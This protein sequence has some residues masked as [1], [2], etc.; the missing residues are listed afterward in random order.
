MNLSKSPT[1]FS[2]LSTN[3]KLTKRKYL[4]IG[5]L[6]LMTVAMQ[7]RAETS[8]ADAGDI[9]AYVK[10]VTKNAKSVNVGD[11]KTIIWKFSTR[12]RNSVVAIDITSDEGIRIEKGYSSF[13]LSLDDNR[14]YEVPV[15]ITATGEGEKNIYFKISDVSKDEKE[16][17]GS[18][19]MTVTVKNAG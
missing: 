12:K 10:P 3:S 9:D 13:N 6:A 18:L 16:Y 1:E 11:T 5:L 14:I 15:K 4:G 8:K 7:P 2:N 17:V 19:S